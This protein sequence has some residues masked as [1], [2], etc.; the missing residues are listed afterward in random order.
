MLAME[1]T[2]T[3]KHVIIIAIR[4]KPASLW[5]LANLDFTKDSTI[6]GTR[7]SLSTTLERKG[8][9]FPLA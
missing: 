4:R 1:K 6:V 8:F 9:E 5:L 3:T 2:I 7:K